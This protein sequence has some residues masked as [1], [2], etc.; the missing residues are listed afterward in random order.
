MELAL[1]DLIPVEKLLLPLVEHR[2]LPLRERQAARTLSRL[3]DGGATSRRAKHICCWSAGEPHFGRWAPA[4]APPHWHRGCD[5]RPTRVRAWLLPGGVLPGG[6]AAHVARCQQ[7]RPVKPDA[8]DAKSADDDAEGQQGTEN[9]RH[10]RHLP[11]R[12]STHRSTAAGEERLNGA[13]ARCRIRHYARRVV[14]VRR[15][16]RCRLGRRRACRA[17]DRC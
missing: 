15:A 17:S 9:V 12:A 8:R 13:S 4:G 14:W 1:D 6:G 2:A 10:A 11:R 7:R 3:G 5:A 16:A